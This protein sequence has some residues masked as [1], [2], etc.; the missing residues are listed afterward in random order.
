MYR[1]GY[2]TVIDTQKIEQDIKREGFKPSI[3]H[4]SNGDIYAL[5]SHPEKKLLVFLEGSMDVTVGENMYYCRKGDTLLIPG[6][7]KHKAVV[8]KDGC[9]FFWAE[10]LE[11]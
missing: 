4:N 10:K 3:I 6:N 7:T 9:I 2:Y 8:G 5:H 11:E 1:K